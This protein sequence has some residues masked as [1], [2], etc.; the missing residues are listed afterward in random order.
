MSRFYRLDRTD[1]G[2]L[3]T[4]GPLA[5]G[6]IIRV[7]RKNSRKP[8][9]QWNPETKC[10]VSPIWV[11]CEDPSRASVSDVLRDE[12]VPSGNAMDAL[13]LGWSA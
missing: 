1:G 4:G 2:P 12:G 9:A 10:W 8:G 3:P 5:I 13:T 7:P 6:T 11:E